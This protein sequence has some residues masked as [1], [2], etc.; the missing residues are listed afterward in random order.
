[1]Q[2]NP[3]AIWSSI[4]SANPEKRNTNSGQPFDY[5]NNGRNWF[6]GIY[7]VGMIFKVQPMFV[8]CQKD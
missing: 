8:K 7:K 4:Q 6:H 5:I 3:L 2:K 1:M